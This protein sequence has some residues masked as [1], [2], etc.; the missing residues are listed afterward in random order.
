MLHQRDTFALPLGF[1]AKTTYPIMPWMGVMMLGFGIGPWFRPDQ[2]PAVR[3]RRLVTLGVAILAGF[4]AL[5]LL[6]VYGDK[7]WFVVEG[8][9]VRTVL[10]FISL[11]KYPASL[12]FLMPTLG[13]G[14]LLLAL[15]ERINASKLIG[16]LAVFGGAPMFFYIFHLAVLRI[17]Y[18]SALAIWGPD[19]GTYY[20]VD[21]YNWIFVWYAALIVPLYFP[22]AW[23][24]RLKR[25]RRDITWLKY[26]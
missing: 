3:Q 18:H 2:D 15:F 26:F 20:G 23:F 24:S 14:V 13:G 19:H 11:T 9:P 8:D 10:S 17:F 16:A 1:V 25:R 22:T 4:V 5:R 12:L 7:P 6:N 21:N